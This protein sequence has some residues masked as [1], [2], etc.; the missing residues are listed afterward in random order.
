MLDM[1][2]AS[3]ICFYCISTPLLIAFLCD[4]IRNKKRWKEKEK[5]IK[6]F[7]GTTIKGKVCKGSL[8]KMDKVTEFTLYVSSDK[9]FYNCKAFKAIKG[10]VDKYVKEGDSILVQA[11]KNEKEYNGKVNDDYLVCCLELNPDKK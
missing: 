9:K 7:K 6:D 4:V 1:L 5:M 8:K 3:F 2:V 10:V 11:N